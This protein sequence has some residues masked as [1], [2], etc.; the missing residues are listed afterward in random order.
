MDS[1]FIKTSEWIKN[2]Q[3]KI[4]P[5]NK[6]D[7][8]FQ[9]SITLSLYY[10][11]IKKNDYRVSKIKPFINNFNWKN[12]NFQ[13]TQQDYQQFEINNESIVLN[14]LQI[15]NQE[16]ISHYYKSQYNKTRENKVI[17]LMLTDNNKQQY[18]FVKK[19]NTLLKN[20]NN[21]NINYFSIDC[22]KRF[23]T[24]L[25]LKEHHKQDC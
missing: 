8:S 23:T 19:F 3:C 24:I 1:T 21:H 13:P 18:I 11:Q 10:E 17:L 2:K 15:N 12:I 4:N 9:Y 14:I 25:G 22:F 6:D 7:K 5:Q 20:K 16:K